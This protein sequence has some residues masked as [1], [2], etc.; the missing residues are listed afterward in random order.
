MGFIVLLAGGN[1]GAVFAL[2]AYVWAWTF[3]KNFFGITTIGALFSNNLVVGIIL[4]VV[5]LVIG[6]LIGLVAFVFGLFRYI[7][8]KLVYK[9]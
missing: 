5:Y 2:A 1:P 7:M 6:Y 4:F 9:Y 3:L 8:L